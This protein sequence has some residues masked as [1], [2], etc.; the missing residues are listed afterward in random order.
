MCFG[1]PV[2]AL[3]AS[4]SQAGLDVYRHVNNQRLIEVKRH[5]LGGRITAN[6]SHT[7]QVVPTEDGPPIGFKTDRISIRP[8]KKSAKSRPPR[9]S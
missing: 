2:S 8:F 5:K 1:S 4:L 9:P 3:R 7:R 6:H